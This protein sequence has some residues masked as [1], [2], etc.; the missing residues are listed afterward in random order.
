[1]DSIVKTNPNNQ[2]IL[3]IN[4]VKKNSMYDFAINTVGYVLEKEVT[5]NA[6]NDSQSFSL[7]KVTGS[8]TI[9]S[10]R[11]VV[12]DATVLNNCTAVK[13][14]LDDGANPKNIS[15]DGAI[16]SGAGVGSIILKDQIALNNL[17]IVLST[18]C[19]VTERGNV[20]DMHQPFEV[21][22]K[23]GV[24]TYLKFSYETTDTPINAKIKWF[25]RC[26]R[27]DGSETGSLE[28]AT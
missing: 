22:Q 14:Y 16:L 12:T 9:E 5:L 27:I 20:D 2:S 24:D 15:D 4:N 11:G 23:N 13:L 1:M 10:I 26:S 7:F 6:N 21:T 25:V 8:I 28:I 19:R 18:E 3:D 17:T